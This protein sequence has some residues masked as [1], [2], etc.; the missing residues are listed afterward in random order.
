[1]L[2][3]KKDPG[4]PNLANFKQKKQNKEEANRKK[5]DFYCRLIESAVPNQNNRLLAIRNVRI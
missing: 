4:V 1:L 3:G 2:E 5:V